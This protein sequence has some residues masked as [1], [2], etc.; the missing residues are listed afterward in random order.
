MV[1]M[2]SCMESAVTK[3]TTDVLVHVLNIPSALFSCSVIRFLLY[4]CDNEKTM[5]KLSCISHKEQLL[6]QPMVVSACN[7][8]DGCAHCVCMLSLKEKVIFHN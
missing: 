5:T 6:P 1:K 4:T 2:N 3:S 8:N 7:V